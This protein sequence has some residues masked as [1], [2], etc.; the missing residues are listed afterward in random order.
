MKINFY[1]EQYGGTWAYN[2]VFN[3][4]Y[5]YCKQN[6]PDIEFELKNSVEHR[7]PLYNGAN[8]KYGPFYLIIENDQTKKYIVV[9]YWD[10]LADIVQHYE[11]TFWDIENCVEIITSSGVHSD[12]LYYQPSGMK[13]TPFSYT[14]STINVEE[15]IE[16]IYAHDI[17]KHIPDKPDF[18]GYLYTFRK[19]L[20]LDSRFNVIDKK[21]HFLY[22]E[23]FIQQLNTQSISLSLNGAGEICNR[24]ME[25]LGVG[26]ALIRQKLVTKFHNN[27]IPDYHYIAVNYDDLDTSQNIESYW[28]QLSDRFIDRYHEVTQ[29]KEFI[30]YVA[31]NGRQWYMENATI[32]A[33]VNLLTQLVDFN[34]L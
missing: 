10:K 16:R 5:E 23:E 29:D 2:A 28:K 27:F 3:K 24:D 14:V 31:S 17:I 7:S 18:R 25:I 22:P 15:Q 32:E 12:D 6:I 9:S 4:F 13:Y 30:E 1:A 19:Y 20:E 11:V 34:K 26:T 8:C 33:N 21:K